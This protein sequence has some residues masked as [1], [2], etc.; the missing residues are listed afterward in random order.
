MIASVLGFG[1]LVFTMYQF[2]SHGR[3]PYV[4]DL[5]TF[6]FHYITSDDT[7]FIIL[8]IELVDILIYYP[9]IVFFIVIVNKSRKA[10]KEEDMPVQTRHPYGQFQPGQFA[11]P[12]Q[13]VQA[14]ANV[15]GMQ[16]V[17]AQP[18][19]PVAYGSL[20]Q[21]YGYSPYGAYGYGAQ[22]VVVATQPFG[23]YHSP[24]YRHNSC[25]F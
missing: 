21:P 10:Y 5:D 25:F 24:Y 7:R 3:I 20:Y 6:D 18:V 1:I 2:Y 13:P 12:D 19:Q 4:T 16:P 11:A 17:Y 15:Q 8:W 14:G 22:P 23:M 9:L